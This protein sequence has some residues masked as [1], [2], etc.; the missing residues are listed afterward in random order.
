MKKS[1]LT[2]RFQQLAGLKP[3]YEIEGEGPQIYFGFP[4]HFDYHTLYI[5][6][7]KQHEEIEEHGGWDNFEYTDS[8]P[9]SEIIFAH[10]NDETVNSYSFNSR[11]GFLDFLQHEINDEYMSWEEA[12]NWMNAQYPD[13][14]SAY[15]YVVLEKGNVVIGKNNVYDLRS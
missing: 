9:L 4:S 2:E 13:G 3:L 1:L 7:T 12:S 10:W 15:G 6:T 14:D 11:D 8:T 5:T